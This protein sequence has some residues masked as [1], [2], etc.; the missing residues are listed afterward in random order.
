MD[1][2]YAESLASASSFDEIFELV[3]KVVSKR[4]GMRRAGLGLILMD[5]PND[6][7][8]FHYIGSNTIVLNRS[9]LDAI[10]KLSGSKVELNSYIFVVLL[11][12]YLHSLGITDEFHVRTLVESIVREAFGEEHPA[13]EFVRKPL[14]AI[15]PKLRL[16][17]SGSVGEDIEV[18]KDFD[19]ENARYIS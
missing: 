18:V 9:L 2:G 11:H 6:V 12:E 10:S 5:L 8:A 19:M 17:G 3:K 7:G 4:L 16:L 14:D 15:Y 13:M 1:E